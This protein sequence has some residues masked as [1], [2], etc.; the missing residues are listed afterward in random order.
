MTGTRVP[1]PGKARPAGE[2]AHALTFFVSREE[3]RAIVRAL[4]AID[5]DRVRALKRVLGIGR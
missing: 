4:R 3:R 2:L 5:A 1:R